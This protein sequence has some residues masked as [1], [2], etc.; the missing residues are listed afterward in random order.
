MIQ[1]E[2]RKLPGKQGESATG[3]HSQQPAS[4]AQAEGWVALH[5]SS[6]QDI[7]KPQEAL[8]VGAATT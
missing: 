2:E 1:E 5:Q 8:Q 7:T 6:L 4:H 3:D